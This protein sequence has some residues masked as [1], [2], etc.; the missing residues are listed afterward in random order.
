MSL[1]AYMLLACR[2]AV[3]DIV[4]PEEQTLKPEWY[5]SHLRWAMLVVVFVL[6]SVDPSQRTSLV[7]V[8]SLLVATAAYNLAVVAL[9]Y[10]KF[11]P[12]YLRELTLALDTFFL[13]ALAFLSGQ[14]FYF[15]LTLLP[16]IAAALQFGFEI[17][18]LITS[19]V[20][21]AYG[22]FIFFLEPWVVSGEGLLPTIISILALF[23]GAIVGSLVTAKERVPESV[24][25]NEVPPSSAY[26][27]RFRAIYE[28]TGELIATLNYQ[29]ALEKMLDVSLADFKET[30]RR[31]LQRPFSMVLFFDKEKDDMYVAASRNLSKAEGERRIKGKT[32]LVGQVISTAEPAI[33]SR[34]ST[35]PELSN[36]SALRRCRSVLCVPLRVGLEMYGVALFGS[37]E[38]DAYS[39]VYMELVTAFCNQAS[40]ALQNAELYHSLQEEKKK[41]LIGDEELRKQ[42]AR[43]LHDGPTQTISSITMRL[44]FVRMLLDTNPAKA[45]EELDKLERLGA[46]AVKEVRTMLFTMRP[47]ILETQGLAAALEQYAQRI[48]DTDKIDVHLDADRLDKR[49]VPHVEGA[50]FFILEE[51]INNARKHAQPRNIWIDLES[52]NGELFAQV[53]DDGQGFDLARV[54]SSYDERTSLG[55]VNMRERARLINGLLTLESRPGEG[56][57]VTL[58]APM[59]GEEELP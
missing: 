36:F 54:E 28:M 43:E 21:L 4:M 19:I 23:I 35:D 53:K 17:S 13:I 25:E 39:D 1:H 22:I 32:G 55:L 47:M 26:R 12:S 42:L 6:S 48:R 11:I 37:P 8:Y 51:A 27:E 40:I 9:L 52:R 15:L 3:G 10:S 5:I 24:V 46:H 50:T 7:L 45:R 59:S 30:A 16:I 44:D 31:S 34:P 49:P 29:L 58:T 2:R 33:S 14:P 38:V 56:T 41:I 57:T 20:I 18:L